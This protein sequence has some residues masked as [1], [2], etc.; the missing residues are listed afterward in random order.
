MALFQLLTYSQGYSFD[1]EEYLHTAHARIGQVEMHAV[2]Q[3][4]VFEIVAQAGCRVLEV[5]DDAWTGYRCG[6]LSNTFL[7][8]K[9]VLY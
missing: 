7:V 2:P 1:A 8:H 6:E 4:R 9:P 3:R 5:L